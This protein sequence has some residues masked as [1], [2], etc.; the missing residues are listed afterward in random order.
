MAVDVSFLGVEG[1][2]YGLCASLSALALLLLMGVLG[3]KR[4][5]RTGSVRIF[6]LIGIPLGI[7]L[8]RVFYCLIDF[9]IF[10]DYYEN[11]WLMLC[12]FDGGLSMAGLFCGLVLAAFITA[13]ATKQPAGELMDVLCA[14]LGLS[15]AILRFGEQFTDLGV[16][17]A[18]SGGWLTASAPWLFVQSRMG[19]LVEYRLNAW[20]YEAVVALVIFVITMWVCTAL[21]RRKSNHSGDVALFFIALYGASQIML[22]SI[23]DDGHM[24]VVFLRVSQVLAACLPVTAMGVL[25]RRYVRI[26]GRANARVWLSWGAML[27]CIAGL[28]LLEFSLDGRLSWGHASMGRDYALVAVLCAGMFVLPASLMWTLNR[29]LYREDRFTVRID[30]D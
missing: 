18:V 11:P 5:L 23:R 26:R 8:A 30:A 15:I 3:Y 12:F 22:E 28:V 10:T 25:T 2:A 16:G 1:Y 6:G 27:L 21:H 19:V 24:L 17:K 4:G 13:R 9:G 20:L 14:P 29:R 7:L